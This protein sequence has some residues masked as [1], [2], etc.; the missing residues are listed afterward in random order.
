MMAESPVLVKLGGSVITDKT[1]PQTPRLE[2]IS[3]LAQE[4]ARAITAR[5]ELRLIV[6]HGSGSFGHVAAKRY[7]TRQGVRTAADWRGFAE[8]AAVAAQ[9]GAIVT[10]AFLQAGLSVWSVQPSASAWCRQ[11]E[12]VSL[13]IAPLK[14]ALAHGLIPLVRGDVAL[15]E[16]QGGTIISTEQILA[17]L[18]RRL[19]PTCLILVGRVN[20]VFEADPLRQPQAR[21]IAE[22]SPANWNVVRR[23]VAGSHGTDVTG[24]MLSKVE[25]MVGLVQDVPGLTVHLISGEEPGALEAALLHP[26]AMRGGTRIHM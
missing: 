1:R 5:P 18:A 24:G 11:G 15:D 4:V 22:I 6:G 3:R 9:L 7:G 19:Q 20:G 8:V 14:Q 21:H 26:E 25:E 12:L 2:V 23:A 16:L 10:G 13:E 17:Y